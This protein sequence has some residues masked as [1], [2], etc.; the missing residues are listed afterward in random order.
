MQTSIKTL[1]FTDL[2]LSVQTGAFLI[3]VEG[4]Q[5]LCPI[6]KEVE[7][8]V[9][10]MRVQ[11]AQCDY[12]DGRSF[13]FEYDGIHFRVTAKTCLDDQW[14]CCRRLR[15]GS[16]MSL[17]TAQGGMPPVLAQSL[18]DAGASPGVV[19]ICGHPGARKSTTASA[20]FLE[21]LRTYGMVGW[22]IE[23][24]QDF[25]MGGHVPPSGWCHQALVDDENLV[26]RHLV[27]TLR[28]QPRFLLLGEVRRDEEIRN[29][30]LASSYG[31]TG[32]TTMHANN[33]RTALH[34][35][36]DQSARSANDHETQAALVAETVNAVVCQNL[37]QS[38]DRSVVR[39]EF[40]FMTPGV[41]RKIAS[42]DIDRLA[43]DMRLQVNRVKSGRPISLKED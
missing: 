13:R 19:L 9:K 31:I 1:E 2:H 4:R 40:L 43:D 7:E 3:G 34:K 10:R 18:I 22:T 8:D 26:S 37:H 24:P 42:G 15:P 30:L 41:R 17:Q 21:W 32:V 28:L 6:P 11:L 25:V 27:D 14:F 36:I 29:M 5:E 16:D 23:C 12:H 38:G 35:F 20:L 33:I 39:Y